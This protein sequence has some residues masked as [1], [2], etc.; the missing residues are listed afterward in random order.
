M[1]VLEKFTAIDSAVKPMVLEIFTNSD[2]ES[3]ALKRMC[4][5]QKSNLVDTRK[6]VK[7]VLGEEGVKNLKKIF[8]R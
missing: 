2:E 4:S 3:E 1:S 5:I 6:I 7:S 8:K